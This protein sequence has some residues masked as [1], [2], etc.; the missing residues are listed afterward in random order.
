[1]VLNRACHVRERVQRQDFAGQHCADE[2]ADAPQDEG[3]ETLAGAP[4]AF[5]RFVVHVK[6]AGNEEEIVADTVEEDRGE[7][8]RRLKCER[9]YT[10]GKQ[11]VARGPRQDANEDR[12]LVTEVLEHERQEKQKND[13]GDLREGHLAGQSGPLQFRQVDRHHHEIEIE[14]DA[15]EE[16][17]TDENCERRLLH[18]R[19]C[20]EAEHLA[21]ADVLADLFWRRV[22]QD[23]RECPE[24]DGGQTSKIELSR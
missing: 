12:F 22:R 18:Q 24:E 21:E 7:N 10:A 15:N 13:I 4:D 11:E 14:R 16:E 6:L 3:N 8:E 9:V 5:V 1:M 19:E 23:Q 17:A 2:R 20:V